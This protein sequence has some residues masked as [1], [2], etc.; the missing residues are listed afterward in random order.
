MTERAAG[1]PR[2]RRPHHLDRLMLIASLGMI[3][4]LLVPR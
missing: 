3:G 1:R 4:W 2:G